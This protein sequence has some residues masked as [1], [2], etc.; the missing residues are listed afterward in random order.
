MRLDIESV[1]RGLIAMYAAL[2]GLALTRLR[3][4]VEVVAPIVISCGFALMASRQYLM[5]R[6]VPLG[7][8]LHS[9]W[10]S[11]LQ[12]VGLALVALGLAARYLV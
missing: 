5:V 8:R 6:A 12:Y 3:V 2:A 11:T 4:G 1:P 9:Q 10:I 7:G